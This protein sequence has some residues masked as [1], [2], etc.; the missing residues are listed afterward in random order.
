MLEWEPGILAGGVH[1]EPSGDT[2][3]R[4]PEGRERLA[5]QGSGDGTRRFNLWEPSHLEHPPPDAIGVDGAPIHQGSH[6][7]LRIAIGD[8]VELLFRSIQVSREA[9]QLE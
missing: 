8:Y 3:V 1:L 5:I 4:V 2:R 6:S 7:G 9:Q